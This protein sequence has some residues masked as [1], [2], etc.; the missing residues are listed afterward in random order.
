V[1][2]NLHADA[3]ET[4]RL[5]FF[6]L[7]ELAGGKIDRVRVEREKHALNGGLRGFLVVDLAGI[8][9]FDR[10]DSFAIIGFNLVRLV[11][12][13]AVDVGINRCRMSAGSAGSDPPGHGCRDD[14]Q[15]CDDSEFPGHR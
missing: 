9:I 10:R 1:A 4:R 7:F 6:Q 12:I 13:A 5:I 8:F 15:G 2:D 11:F 14:Y 3:I